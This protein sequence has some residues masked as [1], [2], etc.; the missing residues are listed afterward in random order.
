M[1]APKELAGFGRID[2]EDIE[3]Y[4]APDIWRRLELQATRLLVA[5]EGYG[6]FWLHIEGGQQ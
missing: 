1:G 6:R 5:I 4:L 2:C 3:V